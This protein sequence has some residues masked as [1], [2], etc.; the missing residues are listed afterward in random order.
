MGS[1]D[2]KVHW[3]LLLMIL[4]LPLISWLSLMLGDLGISVWILPPVSLCCC[5]S[6][7]RPVAL[8]IADL[9]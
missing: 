9:L 2:A 7:E 5:R 1:D 3:L 6:L 8:A 4:S